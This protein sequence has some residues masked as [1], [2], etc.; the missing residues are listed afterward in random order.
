MEAVSISNNA[1]P[2]IGSN[3]GSMLRIDTLVSSPLRRSV[4]PDFFQVFRYQSAD[5]R[6]Y[7]PLVQALKNGNVVVGENFW[8]KD[9]RGDR[10]LLGKEW[11]MWMILRSVQDRG[12]FEESALQ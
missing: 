11:S 4:T 8:P 1:R 12:S 3:S 2:Y 5:G 10:T 9:Y 6:G 7:Q